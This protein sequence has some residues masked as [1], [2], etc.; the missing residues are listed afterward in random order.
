MPVRTFGG[1][2]LRVGFP[3]TLDVRETTRTPTRS[4]TPT[5]V[6]QGVIEDLLHDSGFELVEPLT[7][8]P[9][10]ARGTVAADDSAKLHLEVT[11]RGDDAAMVLTDHAGYWSWHAPQRRQRA[12]G[13]DTATAIFELG[14][15]PSA[16]TPAGRGL[17]DGF[18]AFVLR[19]SAPIIAGAAIKVLEEGVHEGLVHITSIDPQSWA[20]VESLSGVQL[21]EGGSPR[22]LLLVHGAFDS[23]AGAFGPLTTGAGKDFLERAIAD[24]DAIIGFDHRT[25]SADPLANARDLLARLSVSQA[26]GAVVDVICHSRG[27]LVARSLVERLLPAASW[28]GS[29]NRIVF[30]GVP[31]GGTNL[32]EPDRWS[33]LADVYTNLLLDS[34]PLGDGFLTRAIAGSAIKGVGTLVKYLAAYAVDAD[35]VPGLSAMEP[36]G[37]F[38]VDLNR[39]Q[40]HQPEPGQPWFVISSDFRASTEHAKL[41]VIESIADELLDGAND[42]VVETKPMAAIDAPG[43]Y[44]RRALDFGTNS[45]VYHTNYFWQAEVAEAMRAWLFATT[46]AAPQTSDAGPE[47]EG[48]TIGRRGFPADGGT[49]RGFEPNMRIRVNGGGAGAAPPP[50]PGQPS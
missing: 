40:P 15:Q 30:V 35:G 49:G 50:P 39:H 4:L 26:D 7:I 1:G 11:L 14:L 12:L 43:A 27:G 36:D 34:S 37:D 5:T 16:G 42:L 28:S 6:D 8:R 3:A 13:N 31:N 46:A 19:F 24:Y 9:K 45:S 17:I 38:I 22:I 41:K 44:V 20:R 29:V 32:A 47:L 33:K 23:T 48:P 10:Q 25:L 2:D 21:P 18:R